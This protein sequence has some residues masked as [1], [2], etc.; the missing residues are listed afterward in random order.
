MPA[1]VVWKNMCAMRQ[2][3]GR[4]VKELTS[5]I[6]KVRVHISCL[7]FRI[8]RMSADLLAARELTRLRQCPRIHVTRRAPVMLAKPAAAL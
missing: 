7:N 8:R 2:I 1:S 5:N 6:A 3:F 4:P